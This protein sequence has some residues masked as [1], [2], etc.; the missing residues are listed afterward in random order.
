MVKKLLNED[1]K[2]KRKK[3]WDSSLDF[4]STHHERTTHQWM[5]AIKKKEDSLPAIYQHALAVAGTGSKQVDDEDSGSEND[6]AD[7]DSESKTDDQADAVDK[8]PKL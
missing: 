3:G 1:P 4:S 2:K 5:G 7:I 8:D 6:C